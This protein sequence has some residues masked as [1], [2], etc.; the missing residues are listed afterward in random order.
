MR[1]ELFRHQLGHMA[2]F[3]ME[4][5]KNDEHD[6]ISY[7]WLYPVLHLENGQTESIT[8]NMQHTSSDQL[9]KIARALIRVANQYDKGEL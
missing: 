2:Q 3:A 6:S 5:E 9:R 4:I 8:I 7:Q 1:K